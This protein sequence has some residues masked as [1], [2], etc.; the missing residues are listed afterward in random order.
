ML[1]AIY[2]TD[3]EV[4]LEATTKFRKLLSKEKNPPIDRVIECGVVPRFVEFLKSGN[5]M[6][7]FEAA[8]ALTNIASG[9]S[10]HTQVV[11]E[12]GAVP[13]FIQLLSSS[14]LDVREQA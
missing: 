5:T 1:Q 14:V 9:T 12:N 8:W 11:I 6:L 13:L 10:Q 2:S 4:Q 3:E 7:Q